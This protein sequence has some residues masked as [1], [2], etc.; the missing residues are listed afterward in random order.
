[1]HIAKI[2]LFFHFKPPQVSISAKV[3]SSCLKQNPTLVSFAY[4]L[5]VKHPSGPISH[6]QSDFISL[7][8]CNTTAL[9]SMSQT[10]VSTSWICDILMQW[11]RWALGM[12][13]PTVPSWSSYLYGSKH[14]QLQLPIRG[15]EAEAGGSLSHPDLNR[16][17]GQAGLHSETLFQSNNKHQNNKTPQCLR[18]TFNNELNKSGRSRH[19]EM[20]GYKASWACLLVI[21]RRTTVCVLVFHVLASG[22]LTRN[23]PWLQTQQ[24]SY[25]Q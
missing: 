17:P 22:S 6:L 7:W 5:L 21:P 23:K 8:K 3:T 15:W 24:N 25:L 4:Q 1:M 20:G 9:A 2:S 18:S 10:I 11:M 14:W 13:R 16:V 12:H 19:K